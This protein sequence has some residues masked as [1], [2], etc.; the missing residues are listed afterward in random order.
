VCLDFE[1]FGP[2]PAGKATV[3]YEDKVSGWDLVKPRPQ[4]LKRYTRCRGIGQ[5]SVVRDKFVGLRA[6][7]RKGNHDDIIVGGTRQLLNS[8]LDTRTGRL[9]VN[10]ERSLSPESIG[11]EAMQSLR[12]PTRA[13]QPVDAG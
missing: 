10:Q 1:P 6:V 4:G 2:D 9:S 12:I 11:K 3:Q 7:A 13:R 5:I 8:P